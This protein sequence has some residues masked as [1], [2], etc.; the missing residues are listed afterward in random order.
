MGHGL[1]QKGLQDVDLVFVDLFVVVILVIEVIA[2]QGCDQ[3]F[4]KLDL[5]HAETPAE[6]ENV[7]V[8]PLDKGGGE[9]GGHGL[10]AIDH[11]DQF[12][13]ERN[14]DFEF[15]LLFYIFLIWFF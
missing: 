14:L 1:L 5:G 2:S 9:L 11:D 10:V 6:H 15:F 8:T 7:V 12:A 3:L 4:G 13:Y